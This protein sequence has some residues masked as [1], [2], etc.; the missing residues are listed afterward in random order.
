MSKRATEAVDD[1]L[2]ECVGCD[3]VF[4]TYAALCAHVRTCPVHP[5][6]ADFARLRALDDAVRTWVV[7]EAAQHAYIA[8]RNHDP[9]APGELTTWRAMW[10][11]ERML[12]TLAGVEASDA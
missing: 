2:S 7:A 10:A 4:P 1:D 11:A 5:F 9:G 6:A 12:R 3:A 8:E